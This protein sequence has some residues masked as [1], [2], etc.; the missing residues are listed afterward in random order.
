MVSFFS[1]HKFLLN[2][3]D[4]WRCDQTFTERQTLGTIRRV[5]G[6]YMM[7]CLTYLHRSIAVLLADSRD[8]DD[9]GGGGAA[10]DD[11]HILCSCLRAMNMSLQT[12]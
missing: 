1:D 9:G 5:P 12:S 11:V 3:F 8:D 2:P 4:H 7:Q 10:D 6:I